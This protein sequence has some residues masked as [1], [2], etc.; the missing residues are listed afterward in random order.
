VSSA[1][2]YVRNIAAFTLRENA[3][4]ITPVTLCY[5]HYYGTKMYDPGRVVAGLP[6]GLGADPPP[7]ARATPWEGVKVRQKV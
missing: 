4:C 1:E 2:K 5:K 7:C 6:L 3:D